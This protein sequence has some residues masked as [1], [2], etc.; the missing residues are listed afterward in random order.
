MGRFEEALRVINRA[1]EL[2][3]QSAVISL[4]VASPYLY[5]GKYTQ[6]I[7]KIREAK[8]LNPELPLGTY[9]L[10]TCYE[11]LGRFDEAI[12]EYRR[13]A[14]T[15]LGLTGLG[16]VYGRS[17]REEEA[18]RILRQLVEGSERDDVS[19]YHVARVFMGLGDASQ[20]FAWLNKARGAGD[21]RMVMVKVDPKL[22]KLRSD[23]L[24]GD[25][26][27]DLGLARNPLSG[28]RTARF[29]GSLPVL[30]AGPQADERALAPHEA[31]D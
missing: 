1:H 20:T 4:Q 15:T 28:G 27:E 2:E 5:S 14:G 3:P 22:S 8:T 19:A 25:L 18:R 9:M 16:Y 23:P 12:E 10:A 11:Q 13:I 17:G 24:F 30:P 26:L 29:G 31:I 21:E 6:A 7:D